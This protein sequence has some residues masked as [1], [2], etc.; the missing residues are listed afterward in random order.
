MTNIDVQLASEAPVRS[1]RRRLWPGGLGLVLVL[2]ATA[3][4]AER[5]LAPAFI[6]GTVSELGSA[7]FGGTYR[8]TIRC[9]MADNRVSYFLRSSSYEDA[10]ETL[11]W[12]LP[13]C[14][15]RWL[16][17]HAPPGAEPAPWPASWYRGDFFCPANFHH[18]H[19]RIAARSL[20]SAVAS[21]R[22]SARECRVEVAD[23]TECPLLSP[24]CARAFADFRDAGT[25]PPARAAR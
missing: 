25:E 3:W 19:V 22:A 4:S 9:P 18:R 14:D 7:L 21:V 23:Q 6:A 12:T 8:V 11:R 13:F 17:V 1:R 24:G 16:T 2:V 10:H 20:D 15:L 5:G